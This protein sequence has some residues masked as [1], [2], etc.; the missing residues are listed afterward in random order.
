MSTQAMSTKARRLIFFLAIAALALAAGIHAWQRSRPAALPA[1]F[2]A[3]NGRI[4]STAVAV[5]LALSACLTFAC[6]CWNSATSV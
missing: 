3:G 5:E 1:G 4:E 2:V 6:S